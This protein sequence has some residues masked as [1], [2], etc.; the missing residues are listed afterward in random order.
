MRSFRAKHNLLAISA[1]NA[2]TATNTEQTMDT[3]LLVDTDDVIALAPRREDN[4][5]ELTGKEEPDTIYD[6]GDLAEGKLTFNKAQPQHLAILAAFGLGSV[7]TAS[8]GTGYCHTCTPIE[9]DLDGTRS[10]PTFTGAQR[11]G[12]TIGK[13]RFASLAFDQFTMGFAID[14]FVKASGTIKGTG[15]HTDTVT[16]ETITADD[17]V[18][19]LTLAANA[20]EGSTAAERLD[21]V[22]RIRVELTSGVWTEV[23]FSAVSD[24]T[25]AVIDITA[26]GSGS[27]PVTYKV[28]YV[29][30]EP[31][32]A[33]FPSRVVESPLKMADIT[34]SLG[35]KW[36]GSAIQGGRTNDAEI[37]SIDWTMNN[38]LKAMFPPG[39]GDDYAS[40]I[41]R[42]GRTQTLKLEREMRDWVMQNY[43]GSNETFAVRL[44]AV[45]AEFAT[46]ENYKM[47]IVFPKVGII[48][49]PVQVADKV[50]A[51]PGDLAVLEDDTYGSVIV[52]ITNQ[53]A[54]Y[55]A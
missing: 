45:G 22:Q 37:R 35:G 4:A 38:N 31:A 5:S 3:S 13:R 55:A 24:A 48:N 10:V 53:V 26:P 43:Q 41:W 18:T 8:A 36:D 54:T 42:D 28:L 39:S 2:E 34:V 6:M 32:W 11:Y 33:T 19:Q 46:G 29:P 17:D 30:E 9:N 27:T 25:P 50:V 16:E 7:S 49:A 47:E 14:E 12:K 51:E 15:K 1:N 23:D 52:K 44:Y 21:S 20:V 40:R